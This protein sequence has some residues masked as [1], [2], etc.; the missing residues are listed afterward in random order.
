MKLRAVS[1][2][3]YPPKRRCICARRHAVLRHK[4]RALKISV[5]L[6]KKLRNW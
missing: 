5:C 2:G 1:T 3:E 4:D 6:W